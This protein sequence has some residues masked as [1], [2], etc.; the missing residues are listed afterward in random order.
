MEINLEIKLVKTS[1]GIFDVEIY[2]PE[3]G[4]FISRSFPFSPDEHPE[5]DE[6]I[7]QELYSWISLLMDEIGG[8]DEPEL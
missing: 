2:E 6:V 7:S 4:D 8:E 3:T 1:E 5:F